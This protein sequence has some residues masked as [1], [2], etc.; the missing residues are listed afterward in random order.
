VP[1][2]TTRLRAAP[3]LRCLRVCCGFNLVAAVM[4]AATAHARG[5]TT[6]ELSFYVGEGVQGGGVRRV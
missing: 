6:L 5:L 4:A 3:R 1:W 2:L